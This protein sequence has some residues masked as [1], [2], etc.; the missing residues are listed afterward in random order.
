MAFAGAGQYLR[1]PQRGR[2]ARRL[3]DRGPFALSLAAREAVENLKR[4]AFLGLLDEYGFCDVIDFTRRPSRE[5]TSGVVVRAYL[6]HQQGM[7]LLS[8]ANLLHGDSF[9][10]RFRAD[11]RVRAV[12][13]LLHERIPV[14]PPLHHASARQRVPA[15]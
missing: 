5:G 9:Q 6:A 15:I 8:L 12:E 1:T 2:D 3:L 11:P 14:L 13:P 10:R 7:G 4:L